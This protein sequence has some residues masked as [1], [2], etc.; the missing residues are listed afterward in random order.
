MPAY[1]LLKDLSDRGVYKNMMLTI[2]D[3]NDE[4]IEALERFREG[5]K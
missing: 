2:T 5:E 3:D 4:I 1:T